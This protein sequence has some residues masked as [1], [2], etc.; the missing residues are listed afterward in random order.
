MNTVTFRQQNRVMVCLPLR[1]SVG[2]QPVKVSS[3]IWQMNPGIEYTVT[4]NVC[5][6]GCY[7]FLSQ[8]PPLGAGLE[9][10]ITI[11]GDIS[12]VPFARIYCRGKVIRVDREGADQVSVEPRFGVAAMIDRLQEV[13]V[14]SI[15][16]PAGHPTGEAI[17]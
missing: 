14:E 16:T 13:N 6:G 9:M 5:S 17:A 12:D 2:K 11:P 8:E 1:V 3:S 10:E 7:F 4:E 15:P